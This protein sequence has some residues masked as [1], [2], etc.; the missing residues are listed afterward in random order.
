MASA[1]DRRRAQPAW[2]RA[3]HPL[4]LGEVPCARHAAGSLPDGRG[5]RSVRT[6]GALSRAWRRANS[7]MALTRRSL[8]ARAMRLRGSTA[9]FPISPLAN[10]E[11]L[12]CRASTR[13]TR[14]PMRSPNAPSREDVCTIA[15]RWLYFE[16]RMTAVTYI[17]ERIAALRPRGTTSPTISRRS[18][19]RALRR[20][21]R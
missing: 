8:T 5:A 17:A 14:S 12:G 13:S 6:R 21:R 19:R 1:E 9:A 11:C 2:A 18:R 16:S 20:A 10:L 3:R 15:R 7:A 4:S